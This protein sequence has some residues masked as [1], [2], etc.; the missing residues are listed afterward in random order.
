MH[1]LKVQHLIGILL[2]N[3]VDLEEDFRLETNPNLMDDRASELLADLYQS[4]G[5]AGKAILLDRLRFDFKI[6]RFIFIYD[7]AVHF[8]RYRL[9]TLKTALY[10][11]FTFSWLDGYKRLCRTFERDCLKAGMAPRVWNGPPIA[12]KCFG[13][14]MEQ[15]DLTG[16]GASGWKLNA[17]NDGQYDL[18]SRLHGYKLIRIA[19]YENLMMAGSLKRIDQLLMKPKEDQHQAIVNWLMRKME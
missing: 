14:S 19:M 9:Q 2:E 13:P 7:D 1:Q 17:Y 6:G 4:L 15:G 3:K 11:Q 18:I 16:S 5:G 12:A 8:N 10:D